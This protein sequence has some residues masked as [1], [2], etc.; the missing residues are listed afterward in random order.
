M[1]WRTKEIWW[2]DFLQLPTP[3][4]APLLG[5]SEYDFS[6]ISLPQVVGWM[7]TPIA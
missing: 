5:P 4:A 6:W 2:P 1:C 7:V 3:D